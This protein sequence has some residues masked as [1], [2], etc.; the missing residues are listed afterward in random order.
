M[1]I[2][3]IAFCNNKQGKTT[4]VFPKFRQDYSLKRICGRKLQIYSNGN[5][6]F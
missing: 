3:W 6:L 2:N 4:S 1:F 5:K